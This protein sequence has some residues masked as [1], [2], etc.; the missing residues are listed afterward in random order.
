M[1]ILDN[2]KTK[3]DKFEIRPSDMMDG[4]SFGDTI[5]TWGRL[6]YN[7]MYMLEIGMLV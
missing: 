6:L 7:K 3:A 5:A 4:I 2:K 1:I